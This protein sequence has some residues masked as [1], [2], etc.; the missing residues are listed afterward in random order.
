[1]TVADERL[2]QGID[3]KQG[4]GI[5]QFIGEAPPQTSGNSTVYV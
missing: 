1:M 3:M 4:E 5:G 2:G